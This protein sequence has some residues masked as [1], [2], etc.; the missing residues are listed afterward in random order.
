MHP[1][2]EVYFSLSIRRGL[3][4]IMLIM[5][6]VLQVFWLLVLKYHTSSLLHRRR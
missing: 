5:S 3:L 2:A 4:H 6:L 1:T